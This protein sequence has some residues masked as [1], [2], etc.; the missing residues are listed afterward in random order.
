MKKI[1]FLLACITGF[2]LGSQAQKM[3]FQTESFNFGDVPEGPM[4][5]H[6]FVFQNTG[7][8]DLT[9][10]SA[11]GSCGCTTPDYPKEPIAPGK[12]GLIKVQFN[13]AGRPG[14]Q[15]KTVTINSNAVL[16]DGQTSQVLT[17]ESHVDANIADESY[18]PEEAPNLEKLNNPTPEDIKAMAKAKKAAEK[19]AKKAAKAAKSSGKATTTSDK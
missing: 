6:Y 14:N 2:A 15:K 13:T 7:D 16:P 1:L 3:T 17:I 9:I 8:K 18:K 4:V 5:I 10:S 19:A 12:Y 11:R